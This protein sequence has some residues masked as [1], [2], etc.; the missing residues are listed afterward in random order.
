MTF[1]YKPDF[2][3]YRRGVWISIRPR[4]AFAVAGVIFIA[5]ALS[6][7][8]LSAYRFAATGQDGLPVLAVGLVL[9]YC[10]VDWL[11]WRPRQMKRQYDQLK[12]LQV[13]YTVEITEEAFITR[14]VYGE[15]K[16]PWSV[17][18]RWKSTNDMVVLYQSD[19]SLQVCP[20]RVFPS[21]ADFE[22]FRAILRRHLGPERL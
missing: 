21:S 5:L 17:F 15:S 6:I 14:S 2:A 9:G 4:P 19:A 10:G 7:F 3:D 8:F 11:W 18:H 12:V 20:R 1:T 13:E 16:V 22:Q